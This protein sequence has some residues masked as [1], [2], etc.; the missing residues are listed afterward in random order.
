MVE[1][2]EYIIHIALSCKIKIK[3]YNVGKYRNVIDS[4]I[5]IK[6]V[7]NNVSHGSAF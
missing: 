1:K 2:I 7:C 3:T 5:D 4:T 6:C